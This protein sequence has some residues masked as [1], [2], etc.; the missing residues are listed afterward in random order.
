MGNNTISKLLISF[1]I[2][3]SVLIRVVSTI[4][5]DLTCLMNTF[6]RTSIIPSRVYI[7]TQQLITVYK[8][9]LDCKWCN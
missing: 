6:Q 2:H 5:I 9:V 7:K 4:S 3:I 1:N 8:A